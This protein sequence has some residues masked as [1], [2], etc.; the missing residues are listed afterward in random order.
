MSYPKQIIMQTKQ[1]QIAAK[2]EKPIEIGDYV[3]INVP[4]IYKETISEGKGKKKIYKTIDKEGIFTTNGYVNKSIS[5]TPHGLVYEVKLGSIRV[6]NEISLKGI[7]T[8]Y[9]GTIRHECFKAEHVSPTFD[10]C[11]ANPFK[12]EQFRVSF[13]NQDIS[14]ILFKACYG[15]RSND[16][17][18]EPNYSVHSGNGSIREKQFA[19]KTYGGV[20]FNPYIIDANGNKQFYQRD[21]VWNLEQKQLLIDSIYNGIEIGKF[22]FRYKS[23]TKLEEGMTNNGH[24]YSWECVDGK[25]RFFAILHFVQNKYP[26]SNGNYWNDLSEIAKDKLLGYH[27]LSYGEMGET[28]KDGDVIE[29]FLTLNF[30]GTPMSK[31]HIQFV[32]SFKM[33]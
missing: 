9:Q 32:Q 7:S 23:W 22:L 10:E 30:T 21:L 5:N 3:S 24:G 17:F 33:S 26:D 18:N 6:P 4:Y 29:T 28:A 11:G 8:S 14:S 12:K 25:Q 13:Y 20:D 1:E 2:K 16:D 27:N 19:D 31:E 15:R